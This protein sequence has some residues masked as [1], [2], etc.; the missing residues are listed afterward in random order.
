MSF[1]ITRKRADNRRYLK[2]VT[3]WVED[4]LPESMDDVTVM[5]NE[6]QCFEPVRSY[7]RVAT[8]R[9]VR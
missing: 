2:M 8:R 6:L 4:G 1:D 7:T 3:S 9:A 5:V